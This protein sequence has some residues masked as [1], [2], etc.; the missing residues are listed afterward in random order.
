MSNINSANVTADV[1]TGNIHS[2]QLPESSSP[3]DNDGNNLGARSNNPPREWQNLRPEPRG[4]LFNGP[5]A[6]HGMGPKGECIIRAS[7]GHVKL[8]GSTYLSPNAGQ[9]QWLV[10]R[11]SRRYLDLWVIYPR[12]TLILNTQ[13][14]SAT[15][16]LC[17]YH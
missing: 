6:M 16:L 7:L 4:T 1:P 9:W 14:N 10:R 5:P 12:A 11:N 13:R 8:T 17:N 3:A 2:E 15:L